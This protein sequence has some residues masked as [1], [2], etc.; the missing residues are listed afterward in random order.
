MNSVVSL[1]N[2]PAA[3][4]ALVD[5]LAERLAERVV[6][7]I[8]GAVPVGESWRLLSAEQAGELLGRSARWVYAASQVGGPDYLQLP[9]IDVGGAKKYDPEALR[10]WCQERQIPRETVAELSHPAEPPGKG[11]LSG[12]QRIG[13]PR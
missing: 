7:A 10:R 9:Y 12:R 3:L 4:E 6:E 11:R 8:A 13:T 2:A 1:D 5:A